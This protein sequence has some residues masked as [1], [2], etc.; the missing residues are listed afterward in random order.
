M[1]VVLPPNDTVEPLIVT[2]ELVNEALPML[3][4]VLSEPLIVLFVRV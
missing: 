1:I 3:V 4:S 2:A